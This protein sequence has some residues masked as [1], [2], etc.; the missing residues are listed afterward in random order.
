MAPAAVRACVRGTASTQALQAFGHCPGT[1]TDACAGARHWSGSFR[2]SSAGH[3][4]SKYLVLELCSRCGTIRVGKKGVEELL[5]LSWFNFSCRRLRPVKSGSASPTH[6]RPAALAGSG[7][8][9][10]ECELSL[11]LLLEVCL[12]WCSQPS[13]VPVAACAWASSVARCH[14]ELIMSR[15]RKRLDIWARPALGRRPLFRR[16]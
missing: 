1:T 5:S 10:Y 2:R 8:G 4:D 11:G 12:R 7:G 6:A 14:T 13:S 15:G 9:A 3:L 16:S